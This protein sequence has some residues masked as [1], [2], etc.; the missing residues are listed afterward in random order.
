M[1]IA[2][3]TPSVLT[4]W[5]S[6]LLVGENFC[7]WAIWF[8][9]RNTYWA[10]T[11]SNFDSISYKLQHTALLSQVRLELEGQGKTVFIEN[12]NRFSLK[13][14]TGTLEGKPDIIAIAENGTI[15][16]VKTG[17]PKDS[18]ITQVMIYMYAVPRALPKYRGMK[19]DGL[20]AYKDHRVPIP[21]EAIDSM[22]IANLGTLIRRLTA[23]EP[24]RRVPSATE[25]G[26]CRI[27]EQ[28][29]PDRVEYDPNE[30]EAETTEDF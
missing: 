14:R 11:P 26:Y 7:E 28:D 1:T 8:K 19:F 18:D 4:T 21:A 25:C 9:S 29:C 27:T 16:D 13:G 2:R 12:Q 10:K 15:C 30:E 20:V 6:K 22:F 24:T 3:V 5:L 17:Q 23:S